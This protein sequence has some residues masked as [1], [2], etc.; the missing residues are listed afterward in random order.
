M[1][2][3]TKAEIAQAKLDYRAALTYHRSKERV[4][5]AEGEQIAKLKARV[6]MLIEAHSFGQ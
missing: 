1:S 3:T 6:Y 4:T 2:K 5:M